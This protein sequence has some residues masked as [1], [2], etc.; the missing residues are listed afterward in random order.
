MIKTL[1]Q[2]T[3]ESFNF[4]KGN[5]LGLLQQNHDVKTLLND[6][7]IECIDKTCTN[8]DYHWLFFVNNKTINYGVKNYM[9]K[10]K[11]IIKFEFTS[12]NMEE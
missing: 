7:Y 11:D 9:L 3:S 4:T 10:D 12:Q 5:A 2:T 8:K 6:N 1:G